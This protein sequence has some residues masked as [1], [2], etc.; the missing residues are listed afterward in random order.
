M[1]FKGEVYFKE[2]HVLVLNPMMG[3]VEGT[4]VFE[5]ETLEQLKAEYNSNL[6]EPYDDLGPDQYS[7][8]EKNYSKTFRKGSPYEWMNPL[9]DG[10]LENPGIFGHGIHVKRVFVAGPFNITPHFGP[11]PI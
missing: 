10:E 1:L 7:D 11:L 8:G 6:V 2:V 4:E 9:T 5:F 3:G